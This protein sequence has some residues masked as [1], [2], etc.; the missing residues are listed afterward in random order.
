MNHDLYYQDTSEFQHVQFQIMALWKLIMEILIRKGNVIHQHLYWFTMVLQFAE[1]LSWR[2]LTMG[3]GLSST[4]TRYSYEP[5]KEPVRALLH[6]YKHKLMTT[7]NCCKVSVLMTSRE[8]LT[9]L[10]I[11][12]SHTFK[13]VFLLKNLTYTKLVNVIIWRHFDPSAWDSL[14]SEVD[15][16]SLFIHFGMQYVKNYIAFVLPQFTQ[17]FEKTTWKTNKKTKQK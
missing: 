12:C 4:V 8:I 9:I 16:I 10:Y 5:K 2:I 13:G 17:W 7:A 1:Q 6:L 14:W 3:N 15:S 11:R